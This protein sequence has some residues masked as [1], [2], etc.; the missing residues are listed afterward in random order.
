MI[1]NSVTNLCPILYIYQNIFSNYKHLCNQHL[2]CLASQYSTHWSEL[3]LQHLQVLFSWYLLSYGLCVFKYKGFTIIISAY[4]LRIP[5]EKIE[6][7][8]SMYIWKS[9][10][11]PLF[12]TDIQTD[13]WT[14]FFQVRP[15]FD[16]LNSGGHWIK[17]AGVGSGEFSVDIYRFGRCALMKEPKFGLSHIVAAAPLSMMPDL[18][19]VQ[20]LSSV[21][22]PR[23]SLTQENISTAT[24]F[25]LQAHFY[26]QSLT[27]E[28]EWQGQFVKTVCTSLKVP[29]IKKAAIVKKTV[30]R[31]T[32]ESVNIRDQVV[33]GWKDNKAVHAMSTRFNRVDRKTE[34]LPIPDLIS[35]YNHRMG[36]GWLTRQPCG[37][38]SHSIQVE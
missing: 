27:R 9:S 11:P 7:Y 29:I 16:N 13:S 19:K 30:K 28:L 32:S 1:N 31:G 3:H 17:Q 21:L 37:V 4:I 14:L 10:L 25:S 8:I 24:I 12:M 6:I 35:N 34:L 36:G 23:L 22:Q 18:V 5:R 15:I 2:P 26:L 20:M 33:V 38:L